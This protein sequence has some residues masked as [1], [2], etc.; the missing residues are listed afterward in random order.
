MSLQEDLQRI[1]GLESKQWTGD[2]DRP[3]DAR[4]QQLSDEE[5]VERDWADFE[6]AAR[7]F[8]KKHGLGAMLRCL[9]RSVEHQKDL[10][11]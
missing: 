10:P 7:D 1:R 3:D 8:V 2:D 4:S 11:L 9:S 5:I 6:A